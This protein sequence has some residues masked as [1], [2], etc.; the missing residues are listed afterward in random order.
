MRRAMRSLRIRRMPMWYDP[1]T[2]LAAARRRNE[3]KRDT[4]AYARLM[5]LG[6][7][8]TGDKRPLIKPTPANLRMFA[9]TPY[10]R[11]AIKRIKDPIATLPWEIVPKAGVK[12]NSAMQ[13]QIDIAT[14]CLNK[15]NYDDSFRTFVEQLI[16]DA[17]ICGAGAYEHQIGGDAARPLWMWPVDAL[18]IQIYA[19]WSG[20]N[21]EARYC[22]TL[23]YGNIGGIAGVNLRNDELVYIRVDPTTETPFGIGP[24]EVA[25]ATINRKLGVADYAGKMASNA[26]P[27]N[28]LV[29]PGMD[30]ATLKTFRKWWRNDVEGQGQTPITSPPK[31][32][33]AEVLKLRGTDDKALF[34]EYQQFLIREIFVPFGLSPM[35]GGIER[36]V[37]RNTAEVADDQDWNNAI[38][39]MA[40]NIAAYISRESLQGKLGFSQLEF[41]FIGLE[42]D[43][44]L[45]LAKVFEIEYR[46]NATT[47]NEYRERTRKPPMEGQWGDL[48]SADAQIAMAAA[49]GAAVVDDPALPGPK[50]AGKPASDSE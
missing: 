1:R 8:Q 12:L 39:P 45:N 22:Q 7:W 46:N 44:E 38:V 36:D 17:C 50:P 15:P 23:G 37:N 19:A 10:A 21:N 41:R 34:L 47:P 4:N 6:G 31:D 29:M 49:R 33:T 14:A 5:N 20:K 35:N 3:P 42:R 18:S 9:K 26:Q 48:A 25:F 30:Q 43:D 24:L 16:E 40:T 27:E 11:K 28:L 2:W 13:Q 32:S